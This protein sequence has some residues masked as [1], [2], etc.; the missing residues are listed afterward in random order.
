[1]F[2]RYYYYMPKRTTI[3]LEDDIY[4]MLV[5]ESIRRYGTV[6]AISRVI[7]DLLKERLRKELSELI[8]S[9]KL[10]EVTEEEFEEFRKELSKEFEVR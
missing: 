5:R 7:N 1:M 2:K 4:E 8:F 6:R 10:V 9:E 3:I